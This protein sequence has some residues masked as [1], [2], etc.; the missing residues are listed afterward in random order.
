VLV[1][2]SRNRAKEGCGLIEA[3]EDVARVRA[4]HPRA[5]EE[6]LRALRDDLEGDSVGRTKNC[7]PA[8]LT[9]GEM[10]KPRLY[11]VKMLGK[12]DET[13]SNARNGA[14]EGRARRRPDAERSACTGG[15][16]CALQRS[17]RGWGRPEDVGRSA[18]TARSFQAGAAVGTMA[19]RKA[20]ARRVYFCGRTPCAMTT[21]TRATATQ[22]SCRR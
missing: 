20:C 16:P 3:P 4:V 2:R 1:V 17:E 18:N 15:G 8:D 22:G 12:W 5:D 13:L 21:R 10:G 7:F 19:A 9:M 11:W 6:L 14:A